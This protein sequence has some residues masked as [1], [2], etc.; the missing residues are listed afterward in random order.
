[1][2]KGGGMCGEGGHAWPGGMCG[3]GERAWQERRPLQRTVRILLE[4]ILVTTC[5]KTCLKE[6]LTSATMGLLLILLTSLLRI[7][8]IV[9]SFSL[10]FFYSFIPGSFRVSLV[11]ELDGGWGVVRHFFG[12]SWQFYDK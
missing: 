3:R 5:L 2:A 8:C 1:M 7:R 10:Q 6:F 11:T 9:Q 4:C 12:H